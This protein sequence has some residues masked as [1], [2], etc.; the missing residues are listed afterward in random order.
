MASDGPDASASE[1]DFYAPIAEAL[2]QG[3]IVQGVPLAILEH[4]LTLCRPWQNKPNTAWY[5]SP[6]EA[7]RPDAF[8]NHVETIH[9]T[10]RQPGLG[11]VI[12]E[13]CQIDKMKSQQ[14]DEAKWFVAVCPVLPLA[15]I[16]QEEARAAISEG[17]KM[18][19]F[20]LPAFPSIDFPESYVDLRLMWPLRQAMLGERLVGLGQES[21]AALYMHL[22]RFL[23]A[24]EFAPEATCPTCSAPL[25]MAAFLQDAGDA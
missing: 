10:S 8:R 19:F 16:V 5:G 18:A 9:A 25:S 6:S 22:F 11:M 2:S 23:T 21:R 13:D 17:R 1:P 7:S 14:R 15:E 4:P 24:R 12:W 20:P 3:D